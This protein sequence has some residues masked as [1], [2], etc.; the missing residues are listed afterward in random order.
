MRKRGC[1]RYLLGHISS[2]GHDWTGDTVFRISSSGQDPPPAGHVPSQD[3]A[4]AQVWSLAG[5]IVLGLVMLLVA[6]F[7]LRSRFFQIKRESYNPAEDG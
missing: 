1:P 2:R 6:R 3:A 5:I 4:A 7:G